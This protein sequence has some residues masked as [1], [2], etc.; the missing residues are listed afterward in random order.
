MTTLPK[1]GFIFF[2]M[3]SAISGWS[4]IVLQGT[5]QNRET[6][7][8]LP[9]ANIQIEG[10]YKGTI[11]N[12][13]GDFS[14]ALD[15]LPATLVI[16]Y[17]G[18]A[19]IRESITVDTPKYLTILLQP[20]A[21][22]L[23]P[24]VV[25]DEDPAIRIM[26]EVIR[27]KQEWRAS[28]RTFQTEAYTRLV[29]EN[30]TSITSI[31][32]SISTAYWDKERGIREVISSRRQTSN[33][34]ENENFASVGI[35]TNLYDDNIEIAGFNIIG[36]THPNALDHYH[37]HLEGQRQR[38]SQVI[39]DISVAPKSKLQ[40][41]FL[42][43]VA[44]L[45]SIYAILEVDLKPGEAVLF[46]T[47]IKDFDL[48][49]IQQFNNFGTEHW[50]PIDMRVYGSIKIGFIGLQFPRIIIKRI[51]RLTDYKINI[52]V[53]DSLYQSEDL[54]KVDSSRIRLN[55]DTAFTANPEVV[56]YSQDE[57]TAYTKLDSTM[58][59]EKAYQ[60]SGPLAR[61]VKVEVHN[62]DEQ[63]GKKSGQ[64][65]FS[66]ISPIF[67]F[68]R[69]DAAT[70]GLSKKLD[71]S[72]FNFN[73]FG[74]YK[75][76]R[77]D[78]FYGAEAKVSLKKLEHWQF[79]VKYY[80]K[81]DTRYQSYSY[82]Q[83][84]TSI[85][86]LLGYRDYFDFYRNRKFH[87]A[88]SYAFSQVKSRIT[89]GYNYEKHR[90]LAKNTDFNIFGRDITQREN[91][92]IPEGRLQSLQ[93]EFFSEEEYIPLGIVGQNYWKL[94]AEFSSPE[95]F[96]SDF[97]FVRLMLMVDF[98]I[99]TFLRRRLLPN[100]LDIHL[101]AGTHQGELPPQRFGI[102]DGTLQIFSP[103]SVMRSLLSKSYEG[104]KYFGVFWEHN[105]RTVPFELIG[106]RFL[107]TRNI[108]ILLHGAAAKT[109]ISDETL[110][111]LNY[112][113]VYPNQFHYELGLSIN[114][115]FDL[116]RIDFTERLDKPDFYV[117]L[118]FTRF[119]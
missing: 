3:I 10:T 111:T 32:E 94:F 107:A 16:S 83:L 11:T 47:P 89:L 90:S 36:V 68:D 30:D 85:H 45:D 71:F 92:A 48:H 102:I 116:F 1:T 9:A 72:R 78:W 2:L 39:Y 81:T 42:G 103:F 73:V 46:P 76:G 41:T 52:E 13:Q 21:Y 93:I 59:L 65:L 86:T 87:L 50:L 77:Q 51:S 119:F 24:I 4:Q 105:F 101:I 97:D 31:M 80:D 67:T 63:S 104:E 60:P 29:M 40:P 44:V 79:L 43:R 37:F 25:T 5:I 61:F 115:I 49:Y 33:I 100:T 114:S 54:V 118:S 62:D 27:R 91:P 108:G 70:V 106:L 117:G 15:R 69:V 38:D 12:E 17:I 23:E 57:E 75:T 28:L 53:P 113:P 7:Q 99:P 26:R 34:T 64:N 22:E 55:P 56:P 6:G 95:L 8:F 58:T 98:R 35:I 110:Q 20:I 19:T 84:F 82:P 14:I 112:T 18:Y 88:G 96:D 66:N 109:W 74:G